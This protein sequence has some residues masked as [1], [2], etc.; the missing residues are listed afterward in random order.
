V[1]ADFVYDATGTLGRQQ[2]LLVGDAGNKF[3]R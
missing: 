1:K 2:F 3:G